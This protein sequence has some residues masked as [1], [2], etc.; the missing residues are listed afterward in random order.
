MT[1]GHHTPNNSLPNT[2]DNSTYSIDLT[3]RSHTIIY[4]DNTKPRKKKS[5]TFAEQLTNAFG[6]IARSGAM[7]TRRQ[8]T[9]QTEEERRKKKRGY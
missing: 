8:V 6:A 3:S 5:E 1:T 9:E 4:M 7:G 2:I